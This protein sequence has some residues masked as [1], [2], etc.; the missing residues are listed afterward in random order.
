MKVS[1]TLPGLWESSTLCIRSGSST[2]MMLTWFGMMLS[3]QM[4]GH[5]KLK[6]GIM[7]FYSILTSIEPGSMASLQRSPLPSCTLKFA[8]PWKK[9]PSLEAVTVIAFYV[10][11]PPSFYASK[12]SWIRI[13]SFPG[14]KLNFTSILN[15]FLLYFEWSIS[16]CLSYCLLTKIKKCLL[17]ASDWSWNMLLTYLRS[18]SSYDSLL[19]MYLSLDV[20]FDRI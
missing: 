12:T 6:H 15:S 19:M 18:P 9:P 8:T 17:F 14:S 4:Y 10:P 13:L 11:S 1:T 20:V 7:R 3:K 16:N 5:L 2:L